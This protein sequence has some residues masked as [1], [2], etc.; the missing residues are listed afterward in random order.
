MGVSLRY[1][2]SSGI[3]SMT[4]LCYLALAVLV[5]PMKQR[6]ALNMPPPKC[7][8]YK[9]QVPHPSHD[10]VP[11]TFTLK[12]SACEGIV[13][14]PLQVALREI[15][16]KWDK[17]INTWPKTWSPID[18]IRTISY[19]NQ[20]QVLPRCQIVWKFQYPHLFDAM[21][22]LKIT[23]IL[24]QYEEFFSVSIVCLFIHLFHLRKD[25]TV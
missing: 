15:T 17:K 1:F 12:S 10:L 8:H 22:L 5:L 19:V 3:L 23:N 2:R 20:Y 24:S 18:T 14:T 13:T 16:I 25:L 9:Y 4:G 11:Q 6:L 21:I 7:G